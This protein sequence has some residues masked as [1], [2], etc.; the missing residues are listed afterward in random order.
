MAR[1]VILATENTPL[2]KVRHKQTNL[3]RSAELSLQRSKVRHL[4]QQVMKHR[5]DSV[6]RVQY[7]QARNNFRKAIRKAKKL[8]CKTFT[9]DVFN[10][11]SMMK[12]SRCCS[13]LATAG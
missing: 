10:L 3:W 6:L 4:Q 8:S 5:D 13:K 1:P 11:D 9:G 7:K 12:V 2:I